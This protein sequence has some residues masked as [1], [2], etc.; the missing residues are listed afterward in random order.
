MIK[1]MDKPSIYIKSN[2]K[3]TYIQSNTYNGT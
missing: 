3:E 2:L 1:K